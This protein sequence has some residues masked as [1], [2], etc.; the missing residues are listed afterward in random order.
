MQR[1]AYRPA[2][3]RAEQSAECEDHQEDRSFGDASAEWLPLAD[4]RIGR[5]PEDR[6]KVEVDRRRIDPGLAEAAR[7]TAGHPAVP[8]EGTAAVAGPAV[9]GLRGRTEV[10]P[11][12]KNWSVLKLEYIRVQKFAHVRTNIS[13]EPLRRVSRALLVGRR[14]VGSRSRTVRSRAIRCGTVGRL[15]LLLSI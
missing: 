10:H 11:V 1:Q 3:R 13:A 5:C 7:H 2:A 12:T 6:T 8:V 14:T 9:A 4:G 15:L